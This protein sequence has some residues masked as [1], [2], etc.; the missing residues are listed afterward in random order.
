MCTVLILSAIIAV[1]TLVAGRAVSE[2]GLLAG[3]LP[4][5]LAASS[6]KI[7]QLQGRISLYIG[8]VPGDLGAYLQAGFDAILAELSRIPGWL[9]SWLLSLATGFAVKLPDILLFLLT[10]SLGAYF[11]SAS[12][13]Q[14]LRFFKNQIPRRF[15]GKAKIVYMD[16][17]KSLGSWV[18]AQLIMTVITFFVLLLAFL[19]LRIKF[20][21]LL[22]AV[23]ALIDL[24]PVF[25]TGTVLLPWALIEL[26]TGGQPMALGLFITYCAAAVLRNTMQAKL[27]GDQLGLHPLITLVAIYIGFRSVGVLGMILFPIFAV[28]IKRLNDHKIIKLWKEPDLT[29]GGE[30]L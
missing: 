15:Q 2:L 7:A 10:S 8:S 28:M 11:C 6:G 1:L 23:I 30:A 14:L 22:A 12:Y 24:L 19:L 25:G 21:L 3:R 16:L 29:G 4:D 5:F 20:S 13:T 18:K 27:I 9:S 17:R 26:F